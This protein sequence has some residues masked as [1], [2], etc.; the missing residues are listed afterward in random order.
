MRVFVGVVEKHGF[1]A[2]SRS[3]SIPLPTVCRKIAELEKH[4]GAQLLIRSTRKVVVTDQ[5]RRYYESV[6]RI[7]DGLA[8]AEAE[9]A[10][11]YLNP[12]GQLTITAPALFGKR[13]ILPI[14]RDFMAEHPDVTARLLFTNFVVNL[15]D[16][17]ADLGI[18]IGNLRDVSLTA[19]KV[20]EV[21]HCYCASPGYLASWGSPGRPE[22]ITKHDCI[23]FSKSSDAIAWTFRSP[24]H[25]DYGLTVHP[26]ITVNTAD[27]AAE[28]ARDGG[29]IT[30]LYSYQAAPHLADGSLVAI[31]SDFE[32]DPAPVSIVYPAER[33]ITQRARC[34]IDF[35]AP[36]LQSALHEVNSHFPP[37]KAQK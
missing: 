1:T 4:I 26:K 30:W 10:G 24:A 21:R 18:R 13:Q 23:T 31:L 3:L 2:A 15:L 9:A 6:R 16:E 5:G 22:D 33:L 28:A 14:L 37:H 17:H 27:A 20:G 19:K 11:E 7:L 36:R 25:L 29:G 8:E 34:F 12:L 35:A 32:P